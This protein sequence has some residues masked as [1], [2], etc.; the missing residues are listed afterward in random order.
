VI[1][2]NTDTIGP[3]AAE[4]SHGNRTTNPL[5]AILI[6][7]IAH[8]LIAAGLPTADL[9][10]ITFYRS[11]LALLRSHLRSLTP[12]L[13]LH[14]A[15][16][17]QGRDKEAVL[18]SFVRSNPDAN[19]GD[20]LKDWRRIN[21]AITRAR[22]KLILLGS[23]KTLAGGGDVLAGLVRMC[24]DKGWWVDL[25]PSVGEAHVWPEMGLSSQFDE[26]QRSVRQHYQNH[27]PSGLK[28]D[29]G[30]ESLSR[31]GLR[32][33]RH[34]PLSDIEGNAVVGGDRSGLK[35]PDARGKLDARNVLGSKPV[36]RDILN[37][38]M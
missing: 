31:A 6:T 5:E 10:V 37:D 9:G 38:I 35:A 34:A 19:V 18:V 15:D 4:I 36:L 20:L 30:A 28:D 17:F 14:T 21:V 25:Q 13:E 27:A 26:S 2:L 11:Q 12:N 32:S 1:F 29:I 23:A 8:L 22:S 33:G 7:Q 3:L 16:K 24:R